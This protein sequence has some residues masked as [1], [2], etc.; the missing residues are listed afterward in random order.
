M[1][2]VKITALEHISSTQLATEDVFVI[3]DVSVPAT[4]K[5]TIANLTSYV[6][7]ALGNAR[8]VASNLE[9][10]TT[11][12]TAN[13]A[14]LASAI[15]SISAPTS[16]N[17]SANLVIAGNVGT[18]TV[19]VGVDTLRVLGNVGISTTI[20]ANQ[21]NIALNNTQ[22]QPGIYGGIGTSNSYIPMLT[23]D[24]Q[25][26]ITSAQNVA[27]SVDLS[28]AQSNID[29]VSSNV[30]TL[31]GVVNALSANTGSNVNLSGIQTNIDSV[32]DNVTALT[33]VVN[34]LSANTVL[35]LI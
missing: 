4:R 9:S 12:A 35:P 32:S 30:S 29:L 18:D 34:A 15:A 3:D 23:V 10:F 33:G 26:R 14:E 5:L 27:I 25:G 7:V 21:V 19:I 13:A 20:S 22:V 8:V 24:A 11:T 2:N 1:A 28:I 6:S 17:V 16:A 31:T